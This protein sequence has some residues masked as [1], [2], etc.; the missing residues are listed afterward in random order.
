MKPVTKPDGG[1]PEFK[2]ICDPG[3][4]DKTGLLPPLAPSVGPVETLEESLSSD[5]PKSNSSSTNKDTQTGVNRHENTLLDL[6]RRFLQFIECSKSSLVDLNQA[7]E[8]LGVAKRRIYDITNVLEGIDLIE[9]CQ[10]NKVIWKG[11]RKCPESA[12]PTTDPGT[13]HGAKRMSEEEKEL[14]GL[15]QAAYDDLVELRRSPEYL[16]NGYLTHDELA[17]VAK[18]GCGG[19]VAVTA[20]KGSSVE[21]EKGG[22]ELVVNGRDD[23][24]LQTI[25]GEV[26]MRCRYSLADL[27]NSK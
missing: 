19:M 25:S 14:D 24:S 26:A 27:Y 17:R 10:K 20:A 22:R 11:T 16:E 8:Q 21:A 23:V 18:E 3:K 4:A 5:S 12:E 9:K 2:P 1:L 15:I 13:S 7:A 6:T